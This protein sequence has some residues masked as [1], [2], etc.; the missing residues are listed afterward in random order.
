MR[1][2]ENCCEIVRRWCT[3][4][5]V[6]GVSLL[7][8]L[9]LAFLLVEVVNSFIASEI[10]WLVDGVVAGTFVALVQWAYLQ[11]KVR[12]LGWWLI[13]TVAGWLAGL[14][15]TTLFVGP[16]FWNKIGGGV[17][18]GFTIGFAQWLALDPE[19]SR[20]HEWLITTAVGWTVASMIDMQTPIR[21]SGVL[22]E[23]FVI[24]ALYS[25]IS[26]VIL[27]TVAIAV[28]VFILPERLE[29]HI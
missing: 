27:A 9:L 7:L 2:F 29:R 3:W 10:R 28:R 8:G 16:S 21:T 26:M 22:T 12:A 6:T 17:L 11:P 23:D 18:G 20:N 14:L 4:T 5:A 19:N 25:A 15:L 13:A 1:K 24:V